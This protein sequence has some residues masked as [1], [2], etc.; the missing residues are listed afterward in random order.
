MC[1]Q[2]IAMKSLPVLLSVA[3]ASA[4]G[5][6]DNSSAPIY[7]NTSYSAQDRATDLLSRMTWSEKVGQM[8]GVRRLLGSDLSFNQTSYDILSE[9]Q[10]GIL[11]EPLMDRIDMDNLLN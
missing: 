1:H 7:K 2:I 11:G 10:N 9:Y 3:L 4:G 5:A 6:L 8:G